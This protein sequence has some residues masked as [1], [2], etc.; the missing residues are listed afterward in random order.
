M[1]S[2]N[3]IKWFWE[4]CYKKFGAMKTEYELDWAL[5]E[6]EPY[7]FSGLKEYQ[8]QYYKNGLIKEEIIKNG[9]SYLSI[10]KAIMKVFLEKVGNLRGVKATHCANIYEDY[11]N[12][13]LPNPIIIHMVR[14]CKD[15]YYSHKK[16]T[17][18]GI[19]SGKNVLKKIYL[20]YNQ[21]K[22]KVGNIIAGKKYYM[23]VRFFTPFIYANP[24]KIMDEWVITN[25]I[26]LDI[27]NKYPDN[28]II[29]RYEDLIN[30]TE[31]ILKDI[32]KKL[33]IKWVPDF[34]E[35]S[36]LKDR[37]GGSFIANTSHKDNKMTGFSNS[38]INYSLDKL[39]D[40]EKKYYKNVAQNTA[41]KFGY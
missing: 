22:I 34:F 1:L 19:I 11:L 25:D 5:Y 13:F 6:L 7:I 15:V 32:V 2:D 10:Y 31:K 24:I 16:R 28:I 36:K 12:N 14:N 8:I 23:G 27:K 40:Y 18:H 26:A 30:N 33:S 17:K 3:F 29:V 21:Q 38:H 4:R 35:Y 20:Y 37:H 39:N 9:I 41:Q